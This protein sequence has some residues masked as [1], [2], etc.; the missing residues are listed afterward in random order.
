MNFN[1]HKQIFIASSD[2]ISVVNLFAKSKEDILKSYFH[3]KL[4]SS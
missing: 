3:A 2:R 1:S 4:D